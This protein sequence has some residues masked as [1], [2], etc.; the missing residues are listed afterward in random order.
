[1]HSIICYVIIGPM[2][3][4]SGVIPQ[5]PTATVPVPF[6]KILFCAAIMGML[7]STLIPEKWSIAVG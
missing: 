7:K 6:V 1:M 4:C 3:S 5:I 2:L